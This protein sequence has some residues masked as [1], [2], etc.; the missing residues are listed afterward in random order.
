MNK[1]IPILV[2]L[3]LPNLC[4]AVGETFDGT[5]IRQLAFTENKGQVTD[6]YHHTRHDID[7]K[8]DAGNG[9]SIFIGGG[10]I[11]YQFY[12]ADKTLSQPDDTASITYNMYRMD[13]QLIGANPDANIITEQKNPYYETYYTTGTSKDGAGVYSYNKITY[14]DIYPFIDWVLYTK[15]GKL[16]H[17]FIVHPGGNVTSIQLRY[18]GQKQIKILE[19]GSLLASTPLGD[20]IEQAPYTFT[21]NGQVSCNYA[22]SEDVLSYK[23]SEYASTL[24][25]DP[26][27]V[28]STYYG[29]SSWEHNRKLLLDTVDEALYIYGQTQSITNIATIGTHQF[30]LS[31]EHDIYIARFTLHGTRTWGTYYGGEKNEFATAAKFSRVDGVGKP[32]I[33]ISGSTSSISNI[34]SGNVHSKMLNGQDAFLSKFDDSGRLVWGTYYGGSKIDQAIGVAIDDS[35]MVYITG[36]TESDTGIS[37]PGAHQAGIFRNTNEKTNAFIAKFSDSGRLIWGTYYGGEGTRGQNITCYGKYIYLV[38]ITSS[39]DSIST[40]NTHQPIYQGLN[41]VFIA[42]FDLSGTRQWGSYFGGKHTDINYGL[43]AAENGD[44]Y[45]TG[46]TDSD[47]GIATATAH[48]KNLSGNADAYIAKFTPN[49]Q[50][51]WG[52]YYGGEKD[53]DSFFEI[54]PDKYGGIYIA[55]MSSSTTNIATAEAFQ[56]NYAGGSF[57]DGILVKMD[58]SG[59]LIWG[60]YYG[61]ADNEFIYSVV[62]WQEDIFLAGASRSATGIA[63]AAPHQSSLAGEHDAVIAK[64]CDTAPR[65]SSIW[66]EKSICQQETVTLVNYYKKGKWYTTNGNATI[67]SA[68]IVM[69]ITPGLDTIMYIATNACGSDTAVQ[70]ITIKPLP[71]LL[72]PADFATDNGYNAQFTISAIAGA[73]YQWQTDNGAGFLNINDG[74]QYSGT[75]T[76]TLVVANTTGQN[77]SQK[78]RCVVTAN[79][80][81]ETSSAAELFVWPLSVHNTHVQSFSIKPNPAKDVVTIT[82]SQNIETLQV[83]NMVGQVQIHQQ[84]LSKKAE[85]NIMHLAPGIYM[86][87]VN[88]NYAGKLVKQ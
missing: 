42:K 57:W 37:T 16:K 25:I 53:D 44:F 9:L 75:T 39:P 67:T 27:L 28:W 8:I 66:G 62:L 58:T 40:P 86:L 1:L 85:L 23:V 55:G 50:Q 20:I 64:I 83:L 13:V 26:Q 60:T 29:G 15:D 6:Q 88:N 54:A 74:G 87:K 77:H 56:N 21:E 61:G 70:A 30:S 46:L 63:K 12:Q 5:K 18:N 76:S 19:D 68:G 65:L 3:L 71:I 36:S 22:L 4:F 17:E 84:D 79:N 38:G 52:T 51:I 43:S 35:G 2:F 72:Q 59:K 47:Q 48:K 73:T 45:I 10:A 34:A 81:A 82:S 69:G 32:Y 7:F 24:V 31:A 41:D 80:C 49:G 78:F 14:K 11:H 33:Y